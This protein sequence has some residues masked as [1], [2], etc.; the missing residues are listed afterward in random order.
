MH[1]RRGDA[2]VFPHVGLGGRAAVDL[3]I[4]VDEGQVL[5]LPVSEPGGLAGRGCLIN[6]C[7]QASE[8][9]MNVC[10]RVEL[11]ESERDEL[12]A[13]LA[14]ER[15]PARRLKRAQ[16]LLAAVKSSA[17][18]SAAPGVR[19]ERRDRAPARRRTG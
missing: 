10:Y 3:R 1:A 7:V 19:A 13:L 15:R 2:E 8:A 11:H 5:A 12:K 4:G 14:G 18:G 6:Q 9:L 17:T 16:I